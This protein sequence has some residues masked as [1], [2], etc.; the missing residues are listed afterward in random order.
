[1]CRTI[2]I[3]FDIVPLS[4]GG[5]N[6]EIEDDELTHLVIANG[7][8][9]SDIANHIPSRVHMVKQQVTTLLKY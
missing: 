5:Q 6:C 8:N 7:V 9:P 4:L 2:K 1:M 3:M